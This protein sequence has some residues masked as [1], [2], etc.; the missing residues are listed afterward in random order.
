MTWLKACVSPLWFPHV[1]QPAPD[2]LN[3]NPFASRVT[4]HLKA[5][6]VLA[7]SLPCFRYMEE[8]IESTFSLLSF[9]H[10]SASAGTEKN[11][12]PIHLLA[13]LDVKA[14]WFKKWMVSVEPVTCAGCI[15]ASLINVLVSFCLVHS[16]LS[17]TYSVPSC[18]L[19]QHG[20]YSR[21]VVLRLLERKYKC[22]VS[23]RRSNQYFSAAALSGSVKKQ[24]QKQAWDDF[25]E[26][27][28]T[29]GEAEFASHISAL[30]YVFRMKTAGER[31]AAFITSLINIRVILQPNCSVLVNGGGGGGGG[32]TR[33]ELFWHLSNDRLMFRPPLNSLELSSEGITVESTLKLS[34]K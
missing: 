30:S 12:E 18:C 17:L 29:W 8:V 26:G 1:V 28:P 14:T 7:F 19:S 20:Y 9:Q 2:L 3:F 15:S 33:A 21:T 24:P 13:L 25:P 23:E 34:L 31:C 22:L 16:V 32:D 27:I 10:G 6:F 4:I 5:F 11:L